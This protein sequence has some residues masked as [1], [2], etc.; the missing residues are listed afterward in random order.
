MCV[1]LTEVKTQLGIS[2]T[3]EDTK[4]LQLI[5]QAIA[6]AEAE[7]RRKYTQAT[8]T[9]LHGGNGTSRLQLLNP[10]VASI[11]SIHVD[12]DRTFGASTLLT[13]DT[14]YVFDSDNGVV[15]RIGS[16]WPSVLR[17]TRGQVSGGYLQYGSRSL[18][19]T[20]APAFQ[21]IQVIYV[22]GNSTCPEDVKFGIISIVALIR[23]Q[24]DRGGPLTS[25]SLDYY[26]YTL[27]G[28][29]ESSRHLASARSAL[30]RHWRP[31]F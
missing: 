21:N 13:A 10:P 29:E 6:I 27:A 12:A 8:Y 4:L 22:G 16:W 24:Q 17:H 26:S 15:Y 3:A 9:E 19:A 30:A 7:T 28:H 23:I 11:T 18:V 20:E 5:P 2:G 31:I 14:D 25:E 1:S